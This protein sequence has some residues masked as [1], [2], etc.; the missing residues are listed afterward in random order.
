MG[1]EFHKQAEKLGLGNRMMQC[2]EEMSELTKALCKWKRYYSSDPTLRQNIYQ[3]RENVIEE[4]ADTE[5]CLEQLKYLLG[6]KGKVEQIK[7]EKLKRTEMLLME[8]E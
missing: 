5:Y 1:N 6:A 8:R 2:M 4:I 3:I 7:E